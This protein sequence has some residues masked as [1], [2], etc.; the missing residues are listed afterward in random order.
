MGSIFKPIRKAIK[1]V[2]KGVGKLFKKVWKS[3]IGRALLIAGAVYI[4]GG[5][6]GLWSTPF[7]PG[8]AAATAGAATAG[9]ATTAAA[10]ANANAAYAGGAAAGSAAAG[11][12]AATA[13]TAAAKG[14]SV[15]GAAGAAAP[16]TIL[17]KVGAAIK[18]G[19]SKL[20]SSGKSLFGWIE[21][22]P[23]SAAAI[24]TVGAQVMTGMAER[25]ETKRMN[26]NL[27]GYG[28]IDWGQVLGTGSIGGGASTPG[29]AGGTMPPTEFGPQPQA[30]ASP[31]MAGL[32]VN[33]PPAAPSSF[34]PISY[35]GQQGTMGTQPVMRTP[36]QMTDFGAAPIQH[37]PNKG[38]VPQNW[39]ENSP[40]MQPPPT[41]Y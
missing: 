17:G 12:K 36:D 35:G 30:P 28:E 34:S 14:A 24:G 39:W 15:A 33:P 31:M 40:M 13:A 2:F 21:A 38:Y 3:K 6:A 22:H 41:R 29:T 20:L 19:G 37:D 10:L 4:T 32:Q 1:S 16:T 23:V 9:P 27:E 18:A 11:A 8:A 7:T 25:A 5:L 26:K